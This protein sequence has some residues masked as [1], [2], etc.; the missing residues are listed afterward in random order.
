MIMTHDEASYLTISTVWFHLKHK[1][2]KEIQ[3]N[4]K[5]VWYTV[6]LLPFCT[7][8]HFLGF[9]LPLQL[10]RKQLPFEK[11]IRNHIGLYFFQSDDRDL[12][13][14]LLFPLYTFC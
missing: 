1:D 5:R 12:R 13:K 2:W 6:V 10:E 3:F 8:L 9:L 4:T 11:H 7:A 14:L